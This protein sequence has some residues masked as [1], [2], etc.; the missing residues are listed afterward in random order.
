MQFIQYKELQAVAML[1]H[2]LIDLGTTSQNQFHHHIVREQYVWWIARYALSFGI[3]ILPSITIH[4]ECAGIAKKLVDFLH[5]AIGQ[6]VH[7]IDDN[8]A[9]TRSLIGLLRSQDGIHYRDEKG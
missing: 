8:G 9:C 1:H 7:R 2:G 4:R 6:G 5:L 3:Q